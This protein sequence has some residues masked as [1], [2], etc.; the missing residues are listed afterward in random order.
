MTVL[1][2]ITGAD[3]LTSR[4]GGWPSFH[5]AE[6]VRLVMERDGAIG[7]SAEMVV[8]VWLMTDKVDDRGYY[9]LEKHTL[10]RFRFERIAAIRLAGFNYQNV[11]FGLEVAAET[12][13]GEQAFRVTLDSSYGLS[14][15]LVCGRVV[16][17]DVS[18][19][20]DRGEPAS[21]G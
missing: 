8:H 15:S 19:C 17:A 6:V 16:V 14:G 4:F 9:V 10:V 11:L 7:P 21:E 13:E 5:D 18:P 1:E 20:N 2:H 12:V 3:R